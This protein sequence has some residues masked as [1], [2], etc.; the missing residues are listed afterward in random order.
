[1]TRKIE[2]MIFISVFF[3]WSGCL[4]FEEEPQEPD[5]A[6]IRTNSYTI[7]AGYH[8]YLVAHNLTTKE[9]NVAVWGENLTSTGTTKSIFST[10]LSSPSS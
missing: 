2:W 10:S 7:P 3:L 6:T 9:K 1:M 4:L 5:V 8:L